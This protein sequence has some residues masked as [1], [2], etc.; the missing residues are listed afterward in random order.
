MTKKISRRDFLKL[1]GA[2]AATGAVLTGCG[3][4]SRQVVRE[5][6]TQMPEYTFNGKSTY[7]ATTCRECSAGCGLVVRTF[8]GRAL[9]TEGN[10][11]HPVNLG[12]TCARGQATM[13]GLYNPDRNTDPVQQSVRGSG[14]FSKMDWDAAIGVV[15]D[16]LQN[17]D[18]AGI[19]FL[20][21][22][23]PDH[24]FDLVGD[25]TNAIG[26]PAPVRFGALG[27]FESRA[28]LG[29]AAEN[30]LG[31][32]SLPYFDLSNADMTFSFG[33]NFL[34]T[35]LS[36]VAFTRHY[37]QM[38]RGK[39]GGRG[40]LVQF[41]PRLSQTAANADEW[42]PLR[43]GTEGLVAQALGRLVAEKRGQ[44]APQ[45]FANVDVQAASDASGVS[46]ET[47]D[48]L[49]QLFSEAERPLAI[50]GG[51]ALGQSNGLGSAEAVLALNA[52]VNNFGRQGGVS[53]SPS[54]PTAD[55]Y[56]RPASVQEMADF[57]DRMNAGEIHTLFIHGVNPV[58]ELPKAL[59][60]EA[61]LQNVLLV[62]S[63]ATFPDETAL[64]AD[65]IFPDHHGLESWGYQ[66]IA[67]GI[68]QS[69]L[70]G[71][72]PVVVPFYNTQ[73]TA[74]VLLAAS[75]AAGGSLA[76]ALPFQDEVAFIQNK[77]QPLIEQ[78]AA[79][80]N[81]DEI[82]AFAAYF[83]Q[84][85]GWW[86]NGEAL[87]A[88]S[89]NSLDEAVNVEAPEFEGEGE[90]FLVPYISP[91]L[92]E[93]GANKPWLQEIP[94]PT[95]S[96]TWNTWVEMNPETA[97]ELGIENDDLVQITS[98]AGTVEASVY[99]YPAIRPDTIAIPFGQ[100]HTAYGRYA[101]GRGV[102]PAD[103]F[104]LSYNKAGD[105]AFASMKVSIKKVGKI[106]ELARFESKMGVYGEG[107]EEH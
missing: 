6:Y 63:F 83:Q 69:T 68:S 74:D 87:I 45:A 26:A 71:A 17:P 85:G 38:R 53:F 78:K 2:G 37:S 15:S 8:Q 14:N 22:L 33:A 28:T 70:S 97:K 91:V 31:Q 21:G 43:P 106:R 32:E 101:E 35:W 29:K 61:A 7:F 19:A 59:G 4:A 41:E 64:Q 1:A 48:H 66:R 13:Q 57:V 81:A 47:L 25:L 95:T 50:P 84:F 72:Q 20:M 65:Y 49:A 62:I 98:A 52:L 79:N 5:P 92:G 11:N 76:A 34:E 51:A 77:I 86:A 27:M 10:K 67:A 88:P 75:A 60:F 54:S 103:L 94:D 82:N 12:K 100:G 39:A 58:F 107:L 16:A 80:F 73:S 46:M 36:P 99:R 18:P 105:L 3:P 93:A 90:F 23:A 24:L 104:S 42:I 40:Y 96:V 102:N 9:K 56:H 44:S 30:L 55:A 89:S